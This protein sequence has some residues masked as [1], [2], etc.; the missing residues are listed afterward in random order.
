MELY[1]LDLIAR[2]AGIS[3]SLLGFARPGFFSLANEALLVAD[4]FVRTDASLF[5]R[6]LAHGALSAI[7]VCLSVY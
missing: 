6:L 2:S 1:G 4:W 5:A 3:S 7:F